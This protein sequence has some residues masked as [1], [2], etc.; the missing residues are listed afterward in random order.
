MREAGGG[1]VSLTDRRP[2]AVAAAS[3]SRPHAIAVQFRV[4]LARLAPG[5]YTCH[6]NVMDEH[7]EKFAFPRLPLVLLHATSR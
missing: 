5:R 3:A 7:A 4:P 1:R 6:L 2:P